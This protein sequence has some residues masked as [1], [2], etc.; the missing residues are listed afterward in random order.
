MRE[1]WKVIEAILTSATPGANKQS[2]AVSGAQKTCSSKRS[3]C[4]SKFL[5][6]KMFQEC[7][8]QDIELLSMWIFKEKSRPKRKF[9]ISGFFRSSFY[10]LCVRWKLTPSLRWGAAASPT[11]APPPSTHA[12]IPQP[13]ASL[14]HRS[15]TAE[16]A[17]LTNQFHMFLLASIN[18]IRTWQATSFGRPASS[19]TL[20]TRLS[21]PLFLAGIKPSSQTATSRVFAVELQLSEATFITK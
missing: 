7:S 20:S 6:L 1:L 13:I 10:F 5:L 17:A 8:E 2:D 11:Q 16:Q 18:M 9:R 15:I 14:S 4:F 12:L 19:F 21:L 3:K